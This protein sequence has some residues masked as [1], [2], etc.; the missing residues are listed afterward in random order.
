[1]IMFRC[2]SRNLFVFAVIYSPFKTEIKSP[3]PKLLSG[4]NNPPSRN[5]H[6]GD[7]P[8][9][10]FSL[11]LRWGSE[12]G[13]H[14]GAYFRILGILFLYAMDVC[15]GLEIS[16]LKVFK[17]WIVHSVNFLVA[18]ITNI[19]P[20]EVWK[21][22]YLFECKSLFLGTPNCLLKIIHNLNVY[23]VSLLYTV[24]R[25]DFLFMNR[26]LCVYRIMHICVAL[27]TISECLRWMT[28]YKAVAIDIHRLL[29]LMFIHDLESFVMYLRNCCHIFPIIWE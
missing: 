23:Y 25:K 16:L 20:I 22:T 17:T 24:L 21:L 15:S 12:E 4:C 19:L 3:S 2:C 7:V 26:C 11:V 28:F 5:T 29:H 6:C 8:L 18:C 14:M 9:G 1:M 10:I 13:N 27:K